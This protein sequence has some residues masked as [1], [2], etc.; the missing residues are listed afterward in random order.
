MWYI[1]TKGDIMDRFDLEEKI[2]Q[3]YHFVDALN[4]ISYGVMEVGM[5]NDEIVNALD[6]LAVMLKLHTQKLFDTFVQV[7]QL[8][9]HNKKLDF[10]AEFPG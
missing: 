7:Y 4:D 10:P 2:N 9:N 1:G 3:T 6:G 5:T 8:D